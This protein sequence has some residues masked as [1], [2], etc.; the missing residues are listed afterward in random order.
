MT[1]ST[2]RYAAHRLGVVRQLHAT[3][4]FKKPNAANDNGR[5]LQ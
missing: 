3:T 4:W 2:R 5:S 1:E